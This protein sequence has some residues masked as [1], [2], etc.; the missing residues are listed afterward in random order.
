VCVCVCVCVCAVFFKKKDVLID[1][2]TGMLVSANLCFFS[3]FYIYYR[4]EQ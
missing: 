1:K 3:F 4:F 2:S